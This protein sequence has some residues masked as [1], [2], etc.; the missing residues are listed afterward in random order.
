MKMLA[1][2]NLRAVQSRDACAGPAVHVCRL[3]RDER[4]TTCSMEFSW[5]TFDVNVPPVSQ[6]H[7]LAI[8]M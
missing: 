8:C 6:V 1:A 2:K 7:H 4:N 3:A 5:A